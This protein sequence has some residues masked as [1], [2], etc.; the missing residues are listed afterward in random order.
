MPGGFQVSLIS[1]RV[2]IAGRYGLQGDN[3]S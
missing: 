2:L 3:R 1:A